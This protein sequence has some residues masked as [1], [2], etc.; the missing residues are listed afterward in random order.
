[1]CVHTSG[2]AVG[3]YVKKMSALQSNCNQRGSTVP[4][5]MFLTEWGKEQRVTSSCVFPNFLAV[6]ARLPTTSSLR[7]FRLPPCFWDVTQR[8]FVVSYRSFVKTCRSHHQGSSSL[9]VPYRKF[10]TTYRSHHQG[11]SR[12]VVSCRR[13]VEP[14]DHVINGEAVWPLKMAPKGCS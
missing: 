3:Q 1:M 14:I 6:C 9:V 4:V 5:L 11:P 10:G 7:D 2:L 8:I 12:L 13:L